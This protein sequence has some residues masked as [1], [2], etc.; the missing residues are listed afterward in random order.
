VRLD[1]EA[2]NEWAADYFS[3]IGGPYDLLDDVITLGA[4][5]AITKWTQNA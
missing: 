3:R 5:R 1:D 2:F 4:E